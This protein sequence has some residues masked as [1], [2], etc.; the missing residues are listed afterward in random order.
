MATARCRPTTSN[1]TK[2]PATST[3]TG[4]VLVTGGENDERIQASHGTINVQTQ[5][6][7]FY[8]VS[9]SVGLSPRPAADA[10]AV[11]QRAVYANGNPFLFTGRLV[12]KT[13]PREY[14]DLRRNGD[15]VPVARRRTG[16]CRPRSSAWMGRRRAPA[17]ASS[18]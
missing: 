7:R 5:T 18:M 10:A 8:D 6:G 12:V 4:H 3:L 14:A 16:C 2:T 9:G 1:T 11:G 17:T 15:L 13:G